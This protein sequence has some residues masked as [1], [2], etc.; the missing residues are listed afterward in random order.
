MWSGPR[1]ISTAMM[2][3]WENRQDC[4]VCDEPFYACY[5]ASTGLEHP[6]RREVLASQPVDWREVAANL[7]GSVPGNAGIWY[8]KHMA[9][10]LLP[11]MG[12]A[13]LSGMTHAFLIRPP[14]EVV[15]SYARRRDMVTPA[16]LG[17]EVQAE[18]YR[19]MLA[20]GT[21]PPIIL[22]ADVLRHPEAALRAL[23]AS[24]EV[25]FDPAMLTWPAGRRD[26]D[27]VW[28]EH[29]YD[30]VEQSTGFAPWKP[31]DTVLTGALQTVADACRP[32]FE[33]ME[34]RRLRL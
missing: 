17:F 16:D 10:H 26:S 13:W 20:Q 7:T 12:R 2:R 25:P 4:V 3:A 34:A 6:G 28:A 21:N 22:G 14:E 11:E 33:F 24:L 9:Q 19:T 1:N 31:A 23:C 29:W 30:Q 27:G 15:A 18:I 8:Q 5:L 32:A